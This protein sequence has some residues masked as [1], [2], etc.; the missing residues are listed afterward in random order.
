MKFIL[1][2]WYA[3]LF[4]ND[5]VHSNTNPTG[6]I[7][8]WCFPWIQKVPPSLFSKLNRRALKCIISSTVITQRHINL[9]LALRIS[10][11]E[12]SLA[13]HSQTITER[14]C[15]LWLGMNFCAC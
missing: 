1:I 8:F 15:D 2:L 5:L 10:L 4:L 3:S 11:N 13:V 9:Y 7:H 14:P 6:Y 12:R